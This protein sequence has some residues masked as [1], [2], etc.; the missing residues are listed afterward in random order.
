VHP[1]LI[2]DR[3]GGS[4]GHSNPEPPAFV[5][6]LLGSPSRGAL[7]EVHNARR[8]TD[9]WEAQNSRDTPRVVELKAEN[10]AVRLAGRLEELIPLELIPLMVLFVAFVVV[11]VYATV[12]FAD[13]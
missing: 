7:L 2:V 6:R 5:P 8:Q 9:G 11:L 13:A 12:Q 4:C 3:C 10:V 1:R